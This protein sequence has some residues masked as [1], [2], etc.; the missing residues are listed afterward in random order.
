MT[1]VCRLCLMKLQRGSKYF[2]I[3][4]VE[5]FTGFMP[6]RDQL[7][8]CIPE[9]ALDLIPNPVICN[10]CRTALKSAYDF[11][12][13]CMFVEKKIRNFLEGQN[14]RESNETSYDISMI[15]A[16]D[17]P[18]LNKTALVLSKTDDADPDESAVQPE[19]FLNIQSE[20][21]GQLS[22]AEPET[23]ESA[24]Q[25]D[26]AKEES[27]SGSD[28]L[29]MYY[30]PLNKGG[31]PRIYPRH[32]MTVS[33]LYAD[34]EFVCNFCAEPFRSLQL[35]RKHNTVCSKTIQTVSK[36]NIIAKRPHLPTKAKNHLK[37][38]LFKHTDHPYPTDQEKQMLMKET[39]L[40]L[41]QVENWFINARRRILQDLTKLK[42]RGFQTEDINDSHLGLD[43]DFMDL[44]PPNA[45]RKFCST[46]KDPFGA[47]RERMGAE[48]DP[49][50]GPVEAV[51]SVTLPGP[52]VHMVKLEKMDDD[53]EE[54][55]EE[56]VDLSAVKS[57]LAVEDNR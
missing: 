11:K 26:E 18:P 36:K 57:E 21:P 24:D 2:N 31:R 52:P 44:V 6:Y 35:L 7:T 51:E 48:T 10:H 17:V 56:E 43:V 4:A 53:V 20:E 37:K 8:T 16:D 45:L 55:K 47:A 38:W 23:A 14:F 19:K 49:L 25:S 41:L 34:E 27:P 22:N 39:N 5:S 46:I 42:S 15:P 50:E 13:R 32:R 33:R 12:S 40:S 29:K 1:K 9:M 54:I 28:A 3:N 30:K